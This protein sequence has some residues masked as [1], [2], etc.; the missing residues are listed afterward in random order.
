MAMKNALAVILAVCAT[1]SGAVFADPIPGFTCVSSVGESAPIRIE[2]RDPDP[3]PEAVGETLTI[4]GG[5]LPSNTVWNASVAT[6][7]VLNT[8]VVPADTTLTV[9]TNSCVFFAPYTGIKVEPFGTLRVVGSAD[10]SVLFTAANTNDWT[11]TI[12][13]HGMFSDSHGIFEKT[14]ISSHPTVSLSVGI[15]TS[16]RNGYVRIPVNVSGARDSAFHVKWRAIDGT[17][18]FGEDYALASGT[19][20][21]NSTSDEMKYIVVP[22]IA[23]DAEEGDE[24]FTVELYN[25]EGAN[26]GG[27]N[28]CTVLIRAA[29]VPVAVCAESDDSEAIRIET[30]NPD[31]MPDV[32]GNTIAIEGGRLSSNTVWDASAFS[33]N[34]VL[35]T[36]VVPS[37]VTLTVVTNACVYFAPY[38][39][40]R[41]EPGGSLVTS[42]SQEGPVV[43]DSAA[44]GDYAINIVSGGTFTDTWTSLRKLQYGGFGEARLDGALVFDADEGYIRVPVYV[45]GS[46]TT[47]F[48][49]D[50]RVSDGS[51]GTLVWN[52]MNE[53]TKWV[54]IPAAG[55]EDCT[56]ALVEGRGINVSA[57]ACETAV[58]VYANV[59]STAVCAVSPESGY[60]RLECRED[61]TLAKALVRGVEHVSADGDTPAQA[62][63]STQVA[64]GWKENGILVRN[65]ASIA[66]EGGRLS[67][68]AEWGN[69]RTHLVR[70]WVVVPDGVTLTINPGAVVKFCEQTGIKV[71]PGGNVVVAG[72]EGNPVVYTAAADDTIGGNS[73]LRTAEPAFNDYS[74]NTVSGG[75][76]S[77]SWCAIRYAQFANLGMTTVPEEAVA[78]ATDGLVRIPV[79]ISTDRNTMFCV[80]WRTVGGPAASG[81]IIWDNKNGGTKFIDIPITT[82]DDDDFEV[83]LYESMG[84]NVSM[85]ERKCKVKIYRNNLFP[86]GV[87]AVNTD[88]TS[89]R[90]EMR[91][92]DSDL[93]I[94]SSS[95]TR[96]EG[97]MLSPVTNVWRSGATHLVRNWVVVPNGVVLVVNAGAV[98]KFLP[99]TGIRVEPGGLVIADGTNTS[100]IVFTS[101]ADDTAGGDTDG[102]A[103]TPAY[104]NYSID[105]LAGGSFVN[106]ETQMR[107]GTSSTFGSISIEAAAV[108]RKE[109]G[110]LLI[111]VYVPSS[112]SQAFAVD[113][114]A[115]DG[116]ARYGEDYLVRSGRLDWTGSSPKTQF[117]TIPLDPMAAKEENENFTVK[118]M[119]PR[120]INLD[121]ANATCAVTLYDAIDCYADGAIHPTA[122]LWSETAKV[123]AL[124]GKVPIFA[125]G[126]EEIRYS[127]RWNEGGAGVCVTV[128]DALGNAVVLH[129]A[130]SAAEGEA[131]W[132]VGT[133]E[134][135]RYEM[136]HVV[137][138]AEGGVISTNAV[139]FIVNRDVVAHGGRLSTNEVWTADKVHVVMSTVVL[140]DGLSLTIEP[141]AVVK[142]MSG[143]GIV[144]EA[145]A[146][147][148]CNDV[149]LTHAYD[150]VVGGDSFLDGTET[151][152]EFDGY[153]LNGGWVADSSTY[154]YKGSWRPADAMAELR[155]RESG[156]S[157]EAFSEFAEAAAFC[158]FSASEL[159]VIDSP[160]KR[161]APQVKI[162]DFNPMAG[163]SLRF[164]F[165][166]GIDGSPLD[167]AQ[168]LMVS[169]K[170]RVVLVE[171]TTLGGEETRTV[172]PSVMSEDGLCE[173]QMPA[174]N[175][176]SE[177]SRFYRIVVE[178]SA[179]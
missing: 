148:T 47:T 127:T 58:Q 143:T 3:M 147:G 12:V 28:R 161:L 35:N 125:A 75:T 178:T 132:N 110:F 129:E 146:S 34:F 128:T 86:T 137:F 66:V 57:E 88:S 64:D 43:F 104:G 27:E 21:W 49:V 130:E 67:A 167:A 124:V 41:V 15:E 82:I 55:R 116:N 62:W 5:R 105:V 53:G 134:A 80:N 69:D 151:A 162:T 17:A 172:L 87:Y 117:I 131:V 152:P 155:A 42:G 71:E 32:V 164:S 126:E 33:T 95:A 18:R 52:N 165:E 118:L 63:D 98:V 138:D 92:Y 10:G 56:I 100:N 40:I 140:G 153:S 106:K 157:E 61:G 54:T 1:M 174:M 103:A 77:D 73:D 171:Q 96:I 94:V 144:L 19:I 102:K 90:I 45:S 60:V 37:G 177:K 159:C 4:E 14:T 156:L 113:W 145:G 36:V 89:T 84:I 142:F 114:V 121:V 176:S 83:E 9:V 7:F 72:T 39:G 139:M 74:V 168:R 38:T 26:M 65:D 135:G 119:N 136:A 122:S 160:E 111:P 44:E 20:D 166:N 13:E 48:S 51:S 109:D 30:R 31:P 24:S 29:L 8:V 133:C 120:G 163:N 46:R 79:F 175:A 91:A 76:Y 16:E 112:Y 108:V 50:W 78:P 173:V 154:R 179:D 93:E 141:G 59:K 97:G 150:D 123:D 25:A 11:L 2:T 70:N 85:T 99:Y 68:N 158:G 101:I 6:N 107:Y 81:R 115:H 23:D 149:T 22:I 170:V 169:Q